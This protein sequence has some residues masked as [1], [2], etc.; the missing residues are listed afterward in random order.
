[1]TSTTITPEDERVSDRRLAHLFSDALG[2]G[3]PS[4]WMPITTAEMR[5][6]ILEIS[7]RRS[8]HD[9]EAI[10]EECALIADE[11]TGFHD[12]TWRKAAR[13]IANTIRSLKH[14]DTTPEEDL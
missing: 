9:R 5:S 4:D 1:M 2:D 14:S 11:H 10:I 13:L 3:R 8:Q 7:A 6:L 12:A